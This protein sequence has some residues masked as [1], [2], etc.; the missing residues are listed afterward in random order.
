[1]RSLR[2][3]YP[4]R[5]I[6]GML[7]AIAAVVATQATPAAALLP[8]PLQ[9]G[10]TGSAV[11]LWQQDLNFFIHTKQTCRPTLS[12]DSSFGPAT[13]GATKCFQRLSHLTDDGIVGPNTRSAMCDFLFLSPNDDAIWRATCI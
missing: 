7:V 3:R 12:V 1:M 10:S 9:Q 11:A 8:I 2:A 13:T 6:I 5:V 4:V